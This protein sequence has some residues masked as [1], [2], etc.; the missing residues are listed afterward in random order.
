METVKTFGKKGEVKIVAFYSDPGTVFHATG[1]NRRLVVYVDHT[2]G[3][4]CDWP[5]QYD[6][7]RIAYDYPE[8]I[9]RTRKAL[10]ARAYRYLK[11]HP[12]L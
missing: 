1:T 5:I 4:L 8:R 10:V 12:D 11:A 7:G 6:D 9:S 3:C 2:Y